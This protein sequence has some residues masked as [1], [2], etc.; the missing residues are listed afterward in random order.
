MAT[1]F[2]GAYPFLFAML[3]VTI[4]I[5]IFPGIALYLPSMMGR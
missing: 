3:A 5:A 1:I 2:R 4:L